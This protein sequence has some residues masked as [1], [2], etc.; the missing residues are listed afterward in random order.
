MSDIKTINKT[1]SIAFPAT[2]LGWR[3]LIYNVMLRRIFGS[4]RLGQ[5]KL[6]NSHVLFN[7]DGEMRCFS[8]NGIAVKSLLAADPSIT[9]YSDCSHA[10][11]NQRAWILSSYNY[12]LFMK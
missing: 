4:F 7:V 2:N 10:C 6:Q 1:A 3:V 11:E 9:G 8:E 5:P 12:E